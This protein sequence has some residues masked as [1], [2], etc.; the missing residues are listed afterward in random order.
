MAGC[1]GPWLHQGAREQGE[2]GCGVEQHC[3]LLTRRVLSG[4]SRPRS[5]GCCLC[6]AENC[7]SSGVRG[8]W[9]TEW[10]PVVTGAVSRKSV[11]LEGGGVA[12][13]PRLQV[14]FKCISIGVAFGEGPVEMMGLRVST[15]SARPGQP[16][17][18]TLPPAP[19][20]RRGVA[21]GHPSK[22][23]KPQMGGH[24]VISSPWLFIQKPS[25]CCS[26]TP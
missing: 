20:H 16:Y 23:P 14:L 22:S 24:M 6:T 11:W 4:K 18:P 8:K 21:G 15:P 25:L 17:S 9:S 2:A 12:L 7:P 1:P 5:L 3:L 26:N 10:P 13:L 19:A